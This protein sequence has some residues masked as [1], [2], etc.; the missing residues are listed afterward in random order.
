MDINSKIY[1]AGHEGLVGSAIWSKLHKLGYTNVI[2]KSITEMDLTDLS[3]VNT[4][5][6]KEMPE[7]VILVAAKVG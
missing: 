6:D 5:F 4:F 2:G 7:Y 3:Q 1:V